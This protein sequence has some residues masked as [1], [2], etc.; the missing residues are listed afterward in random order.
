MRLKLFGTVYDGGFQMRTFVGSS[1]LLDSDFASL[2][3][4]DIIIDTSDDVPRCIRDWLVA[5]SCCSLALDMLISVPIAS[6]VYRR[7][8]L[9]TLGASG[10]KR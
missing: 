4:M 1:L 2:W 7:V 6:Q 3:Y 9:F 5:A 8:Y 10:E